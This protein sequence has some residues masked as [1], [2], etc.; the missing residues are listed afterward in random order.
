MRIPDA[1]QTGRL[2]YELSAYIAPETYSGGQTGPEFSLQNTCEVLPGQ[3]RTSTAGVQYIASP[4][5]NANPAKRNWAIWAEVA[6]GQAAWQPLLETDALRPGEWYSLQVEA[7]YTANRYVRFSIH[8]PGIHLSRDLS[9][10]R[11]AQEPKFS[12]QAFWLTLEGENLY[13]NYGTA[14]T[15]T[16]KM[17]YDDVTLRRIGP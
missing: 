13:N 11:I 1:G 3:F 2:R 5:I 17:Y 7:D 8:G 4:Y 10:Y 15:F 12:E 16:Y 6:P 9:D 14:G